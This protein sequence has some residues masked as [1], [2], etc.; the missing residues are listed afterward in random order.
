MELLFISCQPETK[1]PP[2]ALIV[3]DFRD[4]MSVIV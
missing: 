4:P 3:P 1:I 2:G